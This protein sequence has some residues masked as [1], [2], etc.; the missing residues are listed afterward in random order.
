M[1]ATGHETVLRALTET[2]DDLP[3]LSD[4]NLWIA[5]PAP[6]GVGANEILRIDWP[7]ISADPA[8]PTNYAILPGDRVFIT[9]PPS[10]WVSIWNFLE[11]AIAG[12]SDP[13]APPL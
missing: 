2:K 3:T 1:P 7:A 6:A 8:S 12:F 13:S 5:R 11:A 10:I 4:K 9:E